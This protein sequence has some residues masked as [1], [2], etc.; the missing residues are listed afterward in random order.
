MNTPSQRDCDLA[1][2]AAGGNTGW[3][4]DHG[5]PAPWPDDFFDPDTD[6]RPAT[7]DTPTLAPGEQPF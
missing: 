4:D 3:W 6:W 5:L 1:T 7:N 2:L